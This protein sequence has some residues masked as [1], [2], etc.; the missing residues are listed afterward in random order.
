MKEEQKLLL[1]S[2]VFA[3][4][5]TVLIVFNRM[6]LVISIGFS[7]AKRSMHIPFALTKIIGA[8]YKDIVF[9]E[10]SFDMVLIYEQ[11]DGT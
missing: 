8:T 1:Q 10:L 2:L 11:N 7:D 6:L 4:E 9:Q 3:M 5:K